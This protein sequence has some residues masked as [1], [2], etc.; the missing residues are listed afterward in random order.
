MGRGQNININRSMEEVDSN[1]HGWLWRVQDFSGGRNCRCGGNSKRTR[2]RSGAW[3]CDWIAAS[4]DKT[5][6]SVELLLREEQRNWF[7][8][9]ESTPGEDAVKDAEMTREDLES[10][11][12]LVDKTAEGFERIDSNLKRTST[13]GKI[14]SDRLS[15]YREIIPERNNWCSQLQCCLSLRDYIS[16]PNFQVPPAW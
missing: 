5:L 10:G 8:E 4:H 16:C 9:L 11:I 2:I 7:L 6:T 1:L 14:Q 13:V 3:R 15:C 12:N